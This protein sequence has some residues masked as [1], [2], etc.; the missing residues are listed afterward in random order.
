MVIRFWGTE[1]FKNKDGVEIPF[2]VEVTWDVIRQIAEED[3]ESV[4][5]ALTFSHALYILICLFIF[6]LVLTCGPLLPVWMFINSMQLIV[7]VPLIAIQLPGNA[8]Y[9]LLENLKIFKLDFVS[10]Y[11]SE[12]NSGLVSNENAVYYTTLVYSCGYSYS[13]IPNLILC[14]IF[15]SLFIL[16]WL[17]LLLRE[18]CHKC[19]SSG[20]A[21][22]AGEHTHRQHQ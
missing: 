1:F 14:L 22:A 4:D 12:Y 3:K 16:L 5:S 2:G 6:L 21:V 20:Q 18:K 10:D 11:S 15:L 7:H 8:H 9:F 13:F 17:A 19:K